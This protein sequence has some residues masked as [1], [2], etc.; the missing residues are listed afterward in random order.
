MAKRQEILESNIRVVKWMIK[1]G[2]TKKECCQQLGIAYNTTRLAKILNDFDLK[3]TR[4]KELKAKAKL[5]KFTELEK[6][7]IVKDYLAGESVTSIAE[8]FF[9]P[10]TRIRP[11]LIE[12]QVPIR[13]RGKKTSSTTD[14]ITQ[15]LAK[16]YKVGDR[17]YIVPN[18]YATYKDKQG[19]TKQAYAFEAGYGKIR[20]VLDDSFCDIW[21]EGRIT[22]KTIWEPHININSK[23]FQKN[24]PN[25]P[26]EGQHYRI[27][28]QNMDGEWIDRL[29]LPLMYKDRLN[30]IEKYGV[31]CYHVII[32]K[33]NFNRFITKHEIFEVVGMETNEI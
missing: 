4:I 13:G 2:K 21:D 9:L 27:M 31:E 32:E 8:R 28:W 25:G 15:D 10:T 1:S 7:Q 19:K 23:T 6:T 29:W 11:I 20:E 18:P 16:K 26:V 12:K 14:H 5:R 24:W 3:E 17:V 33:D 22:E 30:L